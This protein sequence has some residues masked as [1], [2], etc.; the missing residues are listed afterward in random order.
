MKLLTRKQYKDV[1][2]FDHKQMED[3]ILSIYTD[4]F[5]E[6]E[7]K[8]IAALAKESREPDYDAIKEKILGIK[9]IGSVKAEQIIRVLKGE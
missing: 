9:G 5:E 1:K 7:R 3:Y 4:G 8:T 2:K 6:G